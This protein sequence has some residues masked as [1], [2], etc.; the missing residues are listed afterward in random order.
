[1][2]IAPFYLTELIIDIGRVRNMSAFLAT[3]TCRRDSL[4]PRPQKG[5]PAMIGP[6][7]P[8][9]QMEYGNTTNQLKKP[10]NSMKKYSPA[11]KNQ[12]FSSAWTMKAGC[13]PMRH[14]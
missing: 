8:F 14:R 4:K 12:I 11:E 2:T 9:I 10:L 5:F 3:P 13:V 6:T 1:L 7:P